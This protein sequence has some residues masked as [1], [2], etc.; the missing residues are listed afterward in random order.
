MDACT[1]SRAVGTRPREADSTHSRRVDWHAHTEPTDGTRFDALGP[2]ASNRHPIHIDPAV[3]SA[4][5][6]TDSA[7][8]RHRFRIDRTPAPHRP[9]TDPSSIRRR[10]VTDPPHPQHP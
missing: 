4:S 10:S 6:A 3:G 8:I 9:D 1:D 7:S 5:T 2:S